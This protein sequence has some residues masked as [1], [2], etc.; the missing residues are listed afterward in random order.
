MKAIQN[1][2]TRARVEDYLSLVHDFTLEEGITA[3]VVDK[4]GIV[5]AHSGTD[6]FSLEDGPLSL[7]Y[8]THPCVQQALN[9][10]SGRGQHT[11]SGEEVFARRPP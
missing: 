1:G 9:E 5:F 6:L 2:S 11:V 7:N 3:V 8:S 4:S 10:E